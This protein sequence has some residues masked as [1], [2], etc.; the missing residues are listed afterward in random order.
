MSASF[1][2]DAAAE[3]L[4]GVRDCL[5]DSGR[6]R[7]VRNVSR[8]VLSE[9]PALRPGPG[10]L[11][12]RH[13]PISNQRTIIVPF[14]VGTR[15]CAKERTRIGLPRPHCYSLH[16]LLKDSCGPRVATTPFCTELARTGLRLLALRSYCREDRGVAWLLRNAR[17]ASSN[18]RRT[19]SPSERCS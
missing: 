11:A 4:A 3:Q 2:I 7:I 8:H 13:A 5:L 18:V 17:W 12:W 16:A 15:R 19:R 10:R 14:L 6:A 1:V 9:R